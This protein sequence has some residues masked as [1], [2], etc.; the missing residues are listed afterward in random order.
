MTAGTYIELK[1]RTIYLRPLFFL[2]TLDTPA[3]LD[4]FIC[5]ERAPVAARVLTGLNRAGGGVRASSTTCD[6]EF[7][8]LCGTA[9]VGALLPLC[10]RR[11]GLGEESGVS[12][13]V[14]DEGLL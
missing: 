5:G 6:S 2:V 8:R 11:P 3:G 9:A 1:V 10:V 4:A 14:P 12:P 7:I 13:R